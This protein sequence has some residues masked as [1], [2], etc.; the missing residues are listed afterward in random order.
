MNLIVSAASI[1][2]R[3]YWFPR[4]IG[5]IKYSWAASIRQGILE[6]VEPIGQG[7]FEIIAPNSEGKMKI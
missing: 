6:N 7:E 3:I 4:A 2:W 1:Y 5:A